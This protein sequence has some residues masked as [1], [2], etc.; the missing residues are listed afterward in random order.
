MTLTLA[1]LPCTNQFHLPSRCF[2]LTQ[3]QAPDRSRVGLVPNQLR[4]ARAVLSREVVRFERCMRRTI[5]TAN[6][7]RRT[8]FNRRASLN[9]RASLDPRASLK[10]S[11]L[12]YHATPRPV[13]VPRP[14]A[15]CSRTTLCLA[16]FTFAR[17]HTHSSNRIRPHWMF[18]Y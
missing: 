11:P 10:Y 6:T 8:S 12:A 7:Q 3:V 13:D 15:P 17:L 5:H 14:T 16:L 2:T 1:S 18:A 9:N 4:S